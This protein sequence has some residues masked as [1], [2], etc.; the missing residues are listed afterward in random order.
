MVNGPSTE[1]KEDVGLKMQSI[2]DLQWTRSRRPQTATW[3]IPKTD[4]RRESYS[5][6]AQEHGHPYEHQSSVTSSD[7]SS[8]M[9]I[10]GL[11][12][13][14]GQTS[15]ASSPWCYRLSNS[16]LVTP[17]MDGKLPLIYT[18][19]DLPKTS[20]S[21]GGSQ[22][23]LHHNGSQST[24][25]YLTSIEIKT[26]WYMTILHEK[27]R[28]L[29]KLG[30]EINRLSRY[31]VECKKK[32]NI[33]CTLRKENT[34][35]RGDLDQAIS[36]RADLEEEDAGP[37]QQPLLNRPDQHETTDF[38]G[39]PVSSTLP[40]DLEDTALSPGN[41]GIG[42]PGDN[43]SPASSS[44]SS[45][46]K[47]SRLADTDAERGLVEDNISEAVGN[48]FEDGRQNQDR[49]NGPQDLPEDQEKQ[50]KKLQEELDSLQKDN[51]LSKGTV[52]SLQRM[53]SL[54]ESRL[55]KTES[56]KEVLQKELRDRGIQIQAMSAK[57]SSLREER[58]R[59]E[60]LA[61]VEKE[62]FT[63]REL[64]SELKSELAKRNDVVGDF[65]NEVQ[66]LQRESADYQTQLTKCKGERKEFQ[67]RAEDLT[68]SVQH[69]KVALE[70]IQSRFERFRSKIVQATYSAPGV[71]HPLAEITDT[72]VL[73]AMQKIIT[74]R[75]DFH[76][77]LKQKGVKVPPL[78]GSEQL[79]TAKQASS[80]THK[81]KS[82]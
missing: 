51:E 45:S 16:S 75:S 70:C 35:L 42:R 17:R 44:P 73:E 66:R 26:P 69:M 27:E 61:A 57:F 74:E 64:V 15:A 81:T 34:Q 25:T 20:T 55:R 10:S 3:K 40:E 7:P 54:H 67:G 53:I 60:I 47:E 24:Q 76:Q 68:L 12:V 18:S 52:V 43:L 79:P 58:K 36:T 28:C 39:S 37:E 2:Y 14:N 6:S 23:P 78:H 13:F 11:Q 31:E 21:T 72:E 46:Q 56:E 22:T 63:L 71:K 59:E 33:I 8:S 9:D 38:D 50:M 30:E 65:K 4:T 49:T 82:K 32:D 29:M 80:I 19:N 1:M 48:A 41:S 77:Q 62:N 5:K